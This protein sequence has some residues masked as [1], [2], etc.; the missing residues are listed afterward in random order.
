MWNALKLVKMWEGRTSDAVASSLAM[1]GLK[2]D[3]AFA[4]SWFESRLSEAKVQIDELYKDFRLS[5]ILKT[6]YSLIWDD[7]CSWYLEWVKPGFEEPV[8]NA[9]YEKTVSYFEQLLQLL[10]PFMPFV[11]E[12]IYHLLKEQKDDITV[13][14]YP[15][16]AAADKKMLLSGLLLKETITA[17]RDARNKNQLKPKDTIK[18]HVLTETA[19]NYKTIEAIL[20]KQVN[21]EQVSY[22]AVSVPNTINVVVQKD[23]FFIETTTV[24]DAASQKEQ[25]IKD[26]E[27]QKGFL[28]SVEKKLSNERFVQNA[29]QEVVDIEKKK[30]ADAE[31][32]IKAIE[33]SLQGL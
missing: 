7:F 1:T 16:F 18:L 10:H 15:V 12:E 6:L 27:Y 19:G 3:G 17:I 11:T 23:K 30:K 31:A 28:L 2:S 14:Q 8:D 20:A 33:D 21:A 24:L 22:T 26:L 29:K 5:E 25:L 32:K 9:V 13:K 4:I